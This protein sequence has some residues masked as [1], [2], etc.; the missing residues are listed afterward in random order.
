M[1]DGL[2]HRRAVDT[3]ICTNFNVILDNH[4]AYL[5]NLL[6]AFLVRSEAETVGTYNRTGMNGDVLANLATVIDGDI[7]MDDGTVANLHIFTNTGEGTDVNVFTDN[8]RLSHK[9][10][11]MNAHF[12][13]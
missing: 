4:N 9:G 8:G 6:V 12:L 2:S 11:G 5:G 1:N 13:R 3:S 10:K 7:R